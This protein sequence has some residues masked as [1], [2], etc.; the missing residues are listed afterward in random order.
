LTLQGWQSKKE[1]GDALNETPCRMDGWMDGWM[2]TIPEFETNA[3]D[4]P[5][6]DTRAMYYPAA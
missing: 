2:D 5:H 6:L 3:A 4:R 1:I